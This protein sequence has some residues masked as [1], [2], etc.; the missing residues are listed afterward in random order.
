MPDPSHVFALDR[1]KIFHTAQQYYTTLRQT[2]KEQT[3]M[4]GK[5]HRQDK[6]T[7]ASCRQR[8]RTVSDVLLMRTAG[9]ML[10]MAH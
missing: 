5:Q 8:R 6:N 7:M 3:T 2:Y 10:T 1:D 4:V 9:V